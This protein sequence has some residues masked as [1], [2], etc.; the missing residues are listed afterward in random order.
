VKCFWGGR[1]TV[2]KQTKQAC[3]P[4]GSN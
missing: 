4:E 2:D 3:I 1:K